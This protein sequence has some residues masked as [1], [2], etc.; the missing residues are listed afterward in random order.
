MS[1][2]DTLVDAVFISQLVHCAF[3]N[4]SDDASL[5]GLPRRACW[6][7][8]CWNHSVLSV[9]LAHNGG[10]AGEGQAMRYCCWMGNQDVVLSLVGPFDFVPQ[11]VVCVTIEHGVVEPVSQPARPE[12]PVG[13]AIGT[14]PGE[15]A[16]HGDIHG[17]LS[18]RCRADG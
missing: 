2:R 15:R 17:Q 14:S 12:D 16:F 13:A 3:S 8:P 11:L 1:S 5:L 7:L 9:G 6:R 4:H 10:S 18:G